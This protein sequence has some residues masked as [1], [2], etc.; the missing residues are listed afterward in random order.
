MVRTVSANAHLKP[1]PKMKNPYAVKT[2]PRK[3]K[4]ESKAAWRNRW[5]QTAAA[6]ERKSR[7]KVAASVSP[8]ADPMDQVGGLFY[9]ED[10]GSIQPHPSNPTFFLPTQHTSEDES[11]D[12][13]DDEVARRISLS[14]PLAQSQESSIA[15]D[16]SE[17]PQIKK[18]KTPITATITFH[19]DDFLEGIVQRV[20]QNIGDLM[21]KYYASQSSSKNVNSV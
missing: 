18:E 10:P 3:T 1:N 15:S 11:T 20:S 21:L 6:N 19:D 5:H 9:Y 14:P 12:S 13:E 16:S 7:R 2:V 17:K 4:E 8:N